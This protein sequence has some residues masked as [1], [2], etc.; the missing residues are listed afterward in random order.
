[1]SVNASVLPRSGLMGSAAR[2]TTALPRAG[3]VCEAG[4]WNPETF[5]HEQIRGLVRRVFFTNTARQVRQVVF[6]AAEPCTDVG[7]ICDQVGR[8]LALETSA[9]IA[10]VTRNS[11][12][13]EQALGWAYPVCAGSTGIKSWSTQIAIN[14][15]HVPESGL[16]DLCQDSGMGRYWLSTLAGLRNDFEYVVI[17]GPAAGMS[18]ETALLGQMADGIILVLEA[19]STRRAAAR[20][21]KETLVGTQSRL[22][23]AVL[24][25]RTFPIP[26]KLYRRL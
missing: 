13:G 4:D 17:E 23:G 1:M 26:E 20:K 9:D 18:S 25:E 16:R 10:I 2:V 7:A 5:A 24:S 22:L 19:H 6:S 21:I 3:I 11:L 12:L 15:W 14:L 8:V